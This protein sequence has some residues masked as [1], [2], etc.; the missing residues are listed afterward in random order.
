MNRLFGAA[1]KEETPPPPPP[2][3]EEP[4]PPTLPVKVVVP[5]SEQ[6]AKVNPHSF[7][8]KTKYGSFPKL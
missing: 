3:K 5:L 2:K 8:S 7:S 1:K 6:Q 4:A